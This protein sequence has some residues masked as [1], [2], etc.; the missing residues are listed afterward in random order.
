MFLYTQ[1]RVF[2]RPAPYDSYKNNNEEDGVVE[3]ALR[4]AV[5]ADLD[6]FGV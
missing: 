6:V 2:P 4:T 3:V 1:D 5:S